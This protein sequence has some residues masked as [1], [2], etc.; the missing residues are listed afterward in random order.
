MEIFRSINLPNSSDTSIEHR[1]IEKID[2][3]NKSERGRYK[4]CSEKNSQNHGR[5]YAVKLTK[6]ISYVCLGCAELQ[7]IVCVF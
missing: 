2:H 4:Y 5:D 6:K 7:K 3:D 1:L